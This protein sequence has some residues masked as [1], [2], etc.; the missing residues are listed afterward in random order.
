MSY[1]I[2]Y[3]F[4]FTLLLLVP[5]SGC[6]FRSHR[7]E[8]RLSSAKLQEATQEQ[9]IGFINAQAAKV[10]TMNA[11]VEITPSVGGQKKGK[12]T[13]YQNMSG[14]V[15]MRKP[16]MLRMIGL[17]PIIRNKAFDMV[18]D[19]QIFK[20]WVPPQNKFVI[21]RNDIIRPSK[22][23]IEN[24]RPQ[25]ILDALLLREIDTR[26]EVAV[27]E[28]GTELVVDPQS[29]KHVDQADYIIDVIRRGDRG[30]FLS[31]KI[32]FSRVDLLPRRQ[33]VYDML[34][35]IAS[36][37]TYDNFKD[38]S[39]LMFP[40][41]IQILRPQEEYTIGLSISKLQLNQPLTDEQFMLQQPA[42]SQ[43]VRLDQ[44]TNTATSGNNPTQ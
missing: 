5:L 26:D 34:G 7:V 16:A 17:F 10:R 6:L 3:R 9:L 27:L 33:I 8:R 23:P 44:P 25:H 39:G 4:L 32:V 22:Q 31:R 13:E 15:L 36:D 21:G 38:Y 29:H 19:G 24:L 40:H 35:N 41:Y 30:W 42:G 43:L 14:Y 18:S 11:T 12:V 2:R 20:L 37:A 1:L 28:A